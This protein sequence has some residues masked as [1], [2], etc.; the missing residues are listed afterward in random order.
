MIEFF[1]GIKQPQIR[2]IMAGVLRGVISQR[3]LPKVDGG[4][5]AAVEV[6]INN[7]RIA[8]LIRENR[9]E[10]IVDAIAEGEFFEM[11]TF[12]KALIEHVV[13][14]KVDRD[15]RRQRRVEPARLPRR[16]RKTREAAG[17][18]DSPRA[19]RRR[20]GAG[21]S[22]GPAAATPAE[23]EFPVLRLAQPGG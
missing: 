23:P 10:E 21:G 20:R 5:I 11:Q 17:R 1:P 19:R 4:R 13:A 14:G 18:T 16:A 9:T 2:S 3:L 12:T 22:R 8:D 15:T 7:A 6:M